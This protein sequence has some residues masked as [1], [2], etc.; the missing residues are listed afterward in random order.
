[1]YPS[2][3]TAEN[4][5]KRITRTRKNM[6]WMDRLAPEFKAIHLAGA[7]LPQ[8][9]VAIM[10][11]VFISDEFDVLFNVPE[12]RY[13]A[14]KQ[15]MRFVYA[16]HHRFLQH[17][18]YRKPAK[19]WVL[20][21]PSHMLGL[22]ALFEIYPDARVVQT[23]REP[24]EVMASTAS[25]STVLRGTFSDYVDPAL[26]GRETSEFWA[27]MLESFM[28]LRERRSAQQFFDLSYQEIVKDP[29]DAVR[30][31]YLHF[32]N[33]LTPETE[34]RMRDFLASNP[35][36]KHGRHRYTMEQFGIDPVEESPRFDG[37]RKRFNIPTPAA[38][39]TA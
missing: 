21:A 11:H 4:E 35:Q 9:C 16:Y 12:Y 28:K 13:W 27:E 38:P 25:L 8:E 29:I 5:N 33:T 37:Y 30:R 39:Q 31:M 1:M 34:Q 2:P 19:H 7:L 14:E 36:D 10:S 17:L 20:K 32:G 22:E 15:D 23:H 18:Q 6:A 26:I 3:P 24:L